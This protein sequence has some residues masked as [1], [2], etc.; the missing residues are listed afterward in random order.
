MKHISVSQLRNDIRM[1]LSNEK[2]MQKYNLSDGQMKKV[3][4]KLMNAVTNGQ[5]HIVLRDY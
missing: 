5:A 2:L 1:R 3:L 4:D